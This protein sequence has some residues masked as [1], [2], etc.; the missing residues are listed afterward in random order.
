VFEAR[1]PPNQLNAFTQTGLFCT[2]GCGCGCGCGVR[3]SDNER[4][5]RFFL[6][7]K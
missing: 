2:C 1:E 3:R 6:N 4:Q 5:F 7:N